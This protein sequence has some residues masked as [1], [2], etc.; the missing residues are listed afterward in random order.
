MYIN[1]YNIRECSIVG[2]YAAIRRG[3]EYSGTLDCDVVGE[4]A[5]DNS[6]LITE[7]SEV[8]WYR[9]KQ[10]CYPVI[11]SNSPWTGCRSSWFDCLFERTLSL[12]TLGHRIGWPM[13]RLCQKW[14]RC[15]RR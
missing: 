10:L 1:I 7:W 12:D 13:S 3:S 14:D 4:F 15:E 5:S 2:G 9:L 11:I 6:P 8:Q